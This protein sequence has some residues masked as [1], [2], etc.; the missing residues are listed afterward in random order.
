[1]LEIHE[2]AKA[3]GGHWECH[4]HESNNVWSYH[5]RADFPKNTSTPII[6]EACGV[7]MDNVTGDGSEFLVLN[8]SG[9]YRFTFCAWR[10]GPAEGFVPRRA[11]FY[12]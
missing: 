2:K 5:S 11:S 8:T 1:M 4:K 6:V 10:E 3:N 9:L 7:E 12:L